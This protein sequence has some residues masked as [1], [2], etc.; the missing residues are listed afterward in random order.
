MNGTCLL[1]A[2][3]ILLGAPAQGKR[4]LVDLRHIGRMPLKARVQDE[5]SAV[6]EAL[7]KA[8]LPAVTFLLSKLED[9][10]RIPGYGA[11]LDF[12]PRVEVGHVALIVLCD[13]F[14]RADGITPTVPG[15]SWDEILSRQSQ[16]PP[17]WDVY[18]SFAAQYGRSGIRRKVEQL[19][20]PYSGTLM[21]DATERCFRPKSDGSMVNLKPS[22]H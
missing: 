4:D 15:L 19:L 9:K 20:A 6:V 14:K 3:S 2:T 8:G 13:L 5:P 1:L 22:G 12:W 21:W 18:D 10:T 16:D 11:V 7:V 17:A